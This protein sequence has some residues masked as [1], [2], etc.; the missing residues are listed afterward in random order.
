MQ[1]DY[2]LFD[3][4]VDGSTDKR[5]EFL[6]MPT[7][8]NLSSGDYYFINIGLN[9]V[10]MRFEKYSDKQRKTDKTLRKQLKVILLVQTLRTV[11]SVVINES[12]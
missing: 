2:K 10:I 3:N 8:A 4:R 1:S 5:I 6:T 11:Q 7:E 9:A 12:H